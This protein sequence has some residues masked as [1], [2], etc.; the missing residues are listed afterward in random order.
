MESTA[1][2]SVRHLTS[3]ETFRYPSADHSSHHAAA[4]VAEANAMVL[5]G[6]R[7]GEKVFLPMDSA[8]FAKELE[9]LVVDSPA[10][11]EQAEAFAKSAS[12]VASLATALA[13]SD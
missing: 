1:S 13:S 11:A 3:S 10:S 5:S 4:A 2:N 6:L 7:G 12:P 8:D 9:R